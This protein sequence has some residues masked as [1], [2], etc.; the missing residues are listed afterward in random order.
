MVLLLDPKHPSSRRDSKKRTSVSNKNSSQTRRFMGLGAKKKNNAS[1]SQPPRHGSTTLEWS[2]WGLDCRHLLASRLPLDVCLAFD[3]MIN[4]VTIRIDAQRTVQVS[5]GKGNDY[6][7][8]SSVVELCT[9]M[10]YGWIYAFATQEKE[11]Y[12]FFDSAIYVTVADV[13]SAAQR[14]KERFDVTTL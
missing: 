12:V 3:D 4:E 11:I 10:P 9:C 7:S 5:S 8:S 1:I 13:Q 6:N 2:A 14:I